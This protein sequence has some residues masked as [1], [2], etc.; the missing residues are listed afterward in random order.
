MPSRSTSV[1]RAAALGAVIA[2]VMCAAACST[3]NP[4]VG[5]ATASAAVTASPA[6]TETLLPGADSTHS[7]VGEVVAGFPLD[8]IPVPAGAAV[9][10]SSAEPVQGTDLTEVSLNLRSEQD[11]AA[12]LAVVSAPLVAAGFVEG[13]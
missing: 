10:V 2:T 7:A 5:P 4:G 12:L 9:L 1:A 3:S 6:P 13:T 8:L 11:T